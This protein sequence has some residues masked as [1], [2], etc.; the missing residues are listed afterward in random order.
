M[1]TLIRIALCALAVAAGGCSTVS[2]LQLQPG[3]STE[4]DVR[5]A[6]GEPAKTFTLPDG[7]RQFAYPTGPGGMQ[8]YMAYVSTSGSLVRFEDV[9]V[10]SQFRRIVPGTT[11]A[12]E[13]ERLIGP[14]WRKID[15]PNKGQVAW[16]Y[17]Y[18]DGWDYTVDLSVM[19]DRRG[20][21]AE[22]VHARQSR[23]DSGHN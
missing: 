4:A 17:V 11:T 7:T 16:D 8:T 19:I 9:L 14:P 3:K 20:I 2:L 15:F 22:S 5:H 10:E 21:V 13:V 6:L 23:G 12:D 18:R 1:K